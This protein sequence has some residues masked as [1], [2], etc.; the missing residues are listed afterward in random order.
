MT[1][2]LSPAEQKRLST[3]PLQY[4]AP[5]DGYMR[6]VPALFR[7]RSVGRRKILKGNGNL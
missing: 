7:L 1:S 2:R 3:S 4:Q 5:T 6:S